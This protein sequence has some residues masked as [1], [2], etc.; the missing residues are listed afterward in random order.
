MGA[1]AGCGAVGWVSVVPSLG[2]AR[3]RGWP[4]T[5]SARPA[6]VSTRETQ[7]AGRPSTCRTVLGTSACEL[8]LESILAAT[9]PESGKTPGRPTRSAADLDDLVEYTLREQRGSSLSAPTTTSRMLG[10][11][12]APEIPAL[13][14]DPSET[15]GHGWCGDDGF[16][17]RVC[18]AAGPARWRRPSLLSRGVYGHVRH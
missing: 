5:R 9:G 4:A 1:L 7:R 17:P 12:H 16:R 10:A 11:R 6:A 8:H 13:G 14:L 2:G 3:V 15:S 18:S